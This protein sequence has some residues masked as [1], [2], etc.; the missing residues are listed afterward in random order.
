[1]R[2]RVAVLVAATTSVVLLAFLIPSA[3][4]VGR[5][6]ET[7]ALDS[8]RAQIQVLVPLVGL[9]T[10]DG[11]VSEALAG[12]SRGGRPVAV[13][14]PD[15]RWIGDP[16]AAAGLPEAGTRRAQMVHDEGAVRFLQPVQRTDGTA[17]ISVV[18]PR[19]QLRSGVPR[20]WA[21]LGLLG[22]ALFVLSLA[23]AGR[24]AG[25]LTRPVTDLATTAHRL[26]GGDL[27]ARVDPSG[28]PETRD[29]GRALNRLAD[30]IGE[31]LD[32]EREA[33]ADL[34]HRLRTPL[35]AL[36]LD[37]EALPEPHR[38]RLLDDAGTLD[39][40]VDAVI[41][42]ARRPVRQGLGE[43]CD[44]VGVVAD[45][46]RFWALLAEE[47]GRAVDLDLPGGTLP[48]GVAAVDLEVALD[49][50]LGNVFSHTPD[51]TGFGVAV[52]PRAGG[53]AQI[54]VRDDGPGPGPDPVVPR[55]ASGSGS[56]GLGLDIVRRTALA[57]G[58]DLTV[59]PGPSGT[60]VVLLVGPPP[61]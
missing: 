57:S 19:E 44:A 21:V 3:Y 58:G 5:L 7:R 53:G 60:E 1:M 4:L 23:V 61:G 41:A 31:L 35:T 9:A 48:V 27:T 36:R 2:R 26:G 10:D 59:R 54:V 34:A 28:P 17:V 22:V 14:L 18:V 20:T 40:A 50:L 16:L 25:S 12:T 42:E 49:A 37:A 55:G 52:R 56:T 33:A 8:A 45:R 24:L 39:E 43:G 30:R 47:E 15:R 46:V 11:Q 13:R 51:G 38:Q 32:A 6:A 29:V